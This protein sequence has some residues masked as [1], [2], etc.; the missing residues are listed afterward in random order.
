MK[1]ML[2]LQVH[3]VVEALSH[4]EQLLIRKVKSKDTAASTAFQD[5][6]AGSQGSAFFQVS[7]NDSV[8]AAR[9]ASLETTIL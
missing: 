8:S 5:S 6:S 4:A 7:L 1:Y 3:N 2:V 9:L